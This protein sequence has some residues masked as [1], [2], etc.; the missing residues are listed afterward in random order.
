MKLGDG[1]AM[2]KDLGRVLVSGT[3]ATFLAI[4]GVPTLEMWWQMGH[5]AQRK[6]S[7]GG[8][9]TSVGVAACN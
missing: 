3:H 6:Q 8:R 9:V 1:G 4:S 5:F 7:V 2:Y